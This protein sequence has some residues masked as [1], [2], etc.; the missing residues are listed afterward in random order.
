MLENMEREKRGNPDYR[1]EI[2]IKGIDGKTWLVIHDI[3][4]DWTRPTF[5]KA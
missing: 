3:F 1:A 5:Q 2:E 4:W